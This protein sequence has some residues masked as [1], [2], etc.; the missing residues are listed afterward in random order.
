VPPGQNRGFGEP[1]LGTFE[2]VGGDTGEYTVGAFG[3]LAYV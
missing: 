2:D 3:V 1:R